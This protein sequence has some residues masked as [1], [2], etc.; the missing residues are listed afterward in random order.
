VVGA[1][2]RGVGEANRGVEGRIIEIQVGGSMVVQDWRKSGESG[3]WITIWDRADLSWEPADTPTSV[4]C[5]YDIIGGVED[6]DENGRTSAR[7]EGSP[8]T[9]QE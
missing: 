1:W 6:E 5:R 4:R 3:R 7:P 2:V 8:G 9:H